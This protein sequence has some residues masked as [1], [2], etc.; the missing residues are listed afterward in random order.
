MSALSASAITVR[1][2]SLTAVNGV[3]VSVPSGGALGIVGESGSGKT[4]LARAIVG[5]QRVD[6]GEIALDGAA[7]PVKR[8]REQRRSI[9]M[10]YQDPYSS[11]NPRMTVRQTLRELLRAHRLAARSEVDARCAELM[12]QVQL[13]PAALDAYPQQFS[14][15]Q[16]QRIALA[17]ALAANPQV[18]VADEPTSALDASVQSRIVALLDELRQEL[19]LTLIVVTHDLGVVNALCDDVVVMRAGRVVETAPREQFFAAPREAY[20]RELLAAVPRL[21]GIGTQIKEH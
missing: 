20:S 4:T 16:R 21:P 11:L 17:R 3:T 14:G 15:G 1:F 10:V 2:G 19:G 12:Q 13:S 8:A 5:Q 7:L 6:E 9:Q 18:L